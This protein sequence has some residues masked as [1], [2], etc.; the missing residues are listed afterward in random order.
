MLEQLE[1]DPKFRDED[2][3]EQYTE[4]K[5]FTEKSLQT[6]QLMQMIMKGN[7]VKIKC[8]KVT[9]DN[10]VSS[11]FSSWEESN[12]WS[13]GEKWS[14]NMTLF[15]GLM[16]YMAEKRQHINPGVGRTRTVIIDNPFGHA[17]SDHVLNPVF[18]IAEQLGFQMIALTAHAEGSFIR[19]YF[20]VV[21]S[22]RLRE[23]ANGQTSIMTYEK[24]IKHVY[25]KDHDPIVLDRLGR[26]EQLTLFD[27]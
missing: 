8:R 4:I 13:G 15:L 1:K 7:M 22:C 20:P 24:E 23:A 18:Y 25:F 11:G 26:R 12:Q 9:N 2:G 10:K 16:N 6:K 19:E 3:G 14:K 27:L 21:Y 5:K 17:S